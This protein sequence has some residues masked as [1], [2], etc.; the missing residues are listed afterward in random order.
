MVAPRRPA[1]TEACNSQSDIA[2]FGRA[3]VIHLL[4]AITLSAG[5]AHHP[6]LLPLRIQAAACH[7]TIAA[8][9][10]SG[11]A[12]R[13]LHLGGTGAGC[14]TNRICCKQVIDIS[15][16]GT[17]EPVAMHWATSC[18]ARA[19]NFAGARRCRQALCLAPPR[20]ASAPGTH[21][22]ARRLADSDGPAWQLQVDDVL[23]QVCFTRSAIHTPDT[24]LPTL[25]PHHRCVH[26]AG[27]FA[28][29]IRAL[30][31][32]SRDHPLATP[33][34]RTRS[35]AHVAAAGRP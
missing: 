6:R 3:G 30:L 32:G 29:D 23:R 14:R 19:I 21:G 34:S 33:E 10:D 35:S 7:R 24:S 2:I 26:E 9:A 15:I 16:P 12:L 31:K 20:R 4:A 28:K 1:R 22:P 5:C 8:E 11:R 27:K 18:C 25:V 17:L 13:S